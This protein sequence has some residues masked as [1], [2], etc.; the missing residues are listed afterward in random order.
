MYLYYI[1]YMTIHAQYAL[2]NHGHRANRSPQPSEVRSE[3][4]GRPNRRT[5]EK[6]LL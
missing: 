3:P 2:S 6:G 4:A 1:G 5:P